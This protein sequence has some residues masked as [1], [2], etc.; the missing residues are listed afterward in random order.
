MASIILVAWL[1]IALPFA[2]FVAKLIT[3]LW[4]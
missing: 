4:K 2:V 1:V 3:Y